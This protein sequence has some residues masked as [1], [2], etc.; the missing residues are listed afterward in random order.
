[1]PNYLFLLHE[2]PAAFAK[3]S[4]EEMQAIIQKYAKWKERMQHAGV[5]V[6]GT[7]L[8]DGTGRVL[9]QKGGKTTVTDG[10]YT[11]GREVI[12]GIFEVK[13]EN[14]DAAVE[15]AQECPHVEYGVIEIRA[16]EIH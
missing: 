9:R 15:A 8:Q 7:K 10:P 5:V 14:F 4:P 6:G 16:V 11:E 12:G 3:V 13:A 1:M 2:N